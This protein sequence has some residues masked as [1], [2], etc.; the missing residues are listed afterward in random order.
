[1]ETGK[2][3]DFYPEISYNLNVYPAANSVLGFLN[4]SEYLKLLGLC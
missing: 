2:D 4:D 1:M 3:R